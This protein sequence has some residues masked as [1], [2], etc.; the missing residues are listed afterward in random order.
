MTV[1]S[2]HGTL[3][4]VLSVIFVFINLGSVATHCLYNGAVGWSHMSGKKMRTITLF[5]GFLGVLAAVSGIYNHFFN[6]LV[7][8]GVIIPPISA[9]MIA[10]RLVLNRGNSAQTAAWNPVAITSWGLA[11]IVSLFI[12][13]QAPNLPVAVIGLVAGAV[14]YIAGSKLFNK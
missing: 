13:F 3:L 8:L 4:T 11:A 6:W 1:L 14:F 2:G 9:I 5:L 7:L 10:D 12:N